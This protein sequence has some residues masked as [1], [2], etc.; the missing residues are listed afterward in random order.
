MVETYYME[1][2]KFAKPLKD[3]L[4]VLLDAQGIDG[5]TRERMIEGDL[6]EVPTPYLMGETPRY[7]MQ[8]LGGE[9]GRDRIHEDLWANVAVRGVD[10]PTVFDDVRHNN[11]AA[12]IRSMGGVVICLSRPGVTRQS[13]HKS[14]D[15]PR[16]NALV[17]NDATPEEVVERVV[18]WW[19]CDVRT[20][21]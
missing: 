4:R 7:A 13:D 8:T 3:M 6:K 18:A 1:R 5:E 12:A 2:R 11:E 9:W 14:E 10:G 21:R 19:N 17:M 16:Y 15:L 20:I